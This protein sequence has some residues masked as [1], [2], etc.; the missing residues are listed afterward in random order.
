MSWFNHGYMPM[1]TVAPE[2]FGPL[3]DAA[4]LSVAWEQNGRDLVIELAMAQGEK[5]RFTF[6]WVDGLYMS[7]QQGDEGLSPPFSWDGGAERLPDGRV[8][9]L[10][11]F[12]SQGEI[13]FTC[14]EIAAD[15][16]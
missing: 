2:S 12:A 10:L 3:C 8:K 13:R 11:D 6:T 4:L 5:R 15:G 7:I 16:R 9:V 1:S 14:N